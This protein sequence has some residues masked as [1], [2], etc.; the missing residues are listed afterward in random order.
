MET[1]LHLIL[2]YYSMAKAVVDGSC[3]CYCFGRAIFK[4]PF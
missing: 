3:F 1:G 4:M 2:E